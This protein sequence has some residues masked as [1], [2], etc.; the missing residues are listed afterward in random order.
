MKDDSSLH[1][2][3]NTLH[4]EMTQGIDS[5]KMKHFA[6][7]QYFVSINGVVRFLLCVEN[8][9]IFSGVRMY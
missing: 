5:Y 1:L 3:E 7:L 2:T 6:Q 8:C 9:L 4:L